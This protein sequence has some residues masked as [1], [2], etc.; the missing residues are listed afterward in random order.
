MCVSS[1]SNSTGRELM[2]LSHLGPSFCTQPGWVLGALL[3]GGSELVLAAPFWYSDTAG[4]GVERPGPHIRLLHFLHLSLTQ[5]QKPNQSSYV[6]SWKLISMVHK[7]HRWKLR[8]FVDYLGELLVSLCLEDLCF[9]FFLACPPKRRNGLLTA[10]STAETIWH[11]I[12]PHARDVPNMFAHVWPTQFDCPIT[13]MSLYIWLWLEHARTYC[14]P[15]ST[16]RISPILQSLWEPILEPGTFHSHSH[17]PSIHRFDRG[18]AAPALHIHRPHACACLI[19]AFVLWPCLI[20]F[21]C[22]QTADMLVCWFVCWSQQ[23]CWLGSVGDI[24]HLSVALS[25]K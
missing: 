1:S 8:V 5:V 22:E 19:I 24:N 16:I 2:A 12:N 4:E 14:G 17:S 25:S 21:D 20:V 7:H 10:G 9:A 15:T 6:S 23:F 13:S 11:N 3:S 18:N